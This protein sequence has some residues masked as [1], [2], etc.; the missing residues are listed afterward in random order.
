MHKWKYWE[1]P[2]F[3]EPVSQLLILCGT[4]AAAAKVKTQCLLFG[5]K[6]WLCVWVLADKHDS[7]KFQVLTYGVASFGFFISALIASSRQYTS[8]LPIFLSSQLFIPKVFHIGS[9]L[10]SLQ[11]LSIMSSRI[12]LKKIH[13]RIYSFERHVERPYDTCV[14][15][16]L[17]WAWD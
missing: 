7:I 6:G 15:T 2:H 12:S 14:N 5:E 9:S 4:F 10:S 1:E 17:R 16:C 8:G 3:C 13:V 11:R